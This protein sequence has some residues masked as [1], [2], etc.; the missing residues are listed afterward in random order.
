MPNH[1]HFVVRP[2][3][4][5]E[6]SE[7]FQYLAGTHATRFRFRTGSR[8]EGHVYQDRF[9]SFPVESD[10]HLLCVCRYVERNAKRVNLVERAEQ[11]RWCG[12]WYRIHGTDDHLESNW[13]ASRHKDWVDRVNQPLTLS[14]LAAIRTSIRRGAPFGNPEWVQQTAEHLGLEF[15]LRPQGALAMPVPKPAAKPIQCSPRRVLVIIREEFIGDDFRSDYGVRLSNARRENRQRKSAK[16][17]RPFPGRRRHKPPEP[18]VV[19]KLADE[20]KPKFQK[21]FQAA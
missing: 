5:E 7:Y 16:E 15:T 12:L 2:Q 4:K 13:P 20:L 6:L 19:L 3:T 11:R 17:R 1:W 8:G 18:P 9:K 14:E 10:G 21:H